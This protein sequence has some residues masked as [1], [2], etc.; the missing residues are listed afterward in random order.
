MSLNCQEIN[1][2]LSELNIDGYF[3][4]DIIQPGY[5]TLALYLYAN[6]TPKTLLIC[7]AQNSCRLHETRRKINKND[8]PLRFME[9][10]KSK[11]KGARIESCYQIGLLRIVQMNL[12][13]GDENFT[14]YIRLWSNASNVI[15]CDKEN[16]IL[17]SMFRRP[18][19]DEVSGGIFKLPEEQIQQKIWPVRD[20][21][22]AQQE[23]KE[24]FPKAPPMTF[25]QKVDYWYGEHAQSLSIQALLAQTEKWY[26]QSRSQM[27]NALEKLLSKRN[28]FENAQ[29]YKHQGDLIMSYSH[30]LDGT[31][32]YLQC[33]DYETGT[34][35]R[36]P[37]DPA[38]SAHENAAT[39]YQQYK[40]AISGAS[41]LDHDIE[42]AKAQIS[43][44]DQQYQQIISEKNP[45]RMEQLFRKDS[46]PKQKIKKTHPG[47]S[48]IINDWYI[49]VGRD[50]NENDELLRH[51]VRGADMWLHVRDFPGGYV[52]IKNR[53]GKTVPLEILLD[54]AN[55]AAY[56]SK[57][58]NAG[59]VDLYYTHVKYLRRAKDGPKGLVLPTH[60]K[61]LCIT[62]DQAR[63]NKLDMLHQT[64]SFEQNPNKKRKSST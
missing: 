36:I 53:P 21:A 61:N 47:L 59:K 14:L 22:E 4:Q 25:N 13:H 7:T 27:E 54:A 55:L 3:I 45:V 50:A 41:A 1:A 46:T 37:V 24:K 31:S 15:L 62:L 2:V 64:S 34:T 6:G 26:N 42:I 48:Y 29:N 30:L 43:K 44:L 49:I 52:F 32:K 19:K 11:V 57:A 56:Y 20:F 5:D 18:G 10:L 16:K 39:Y 63:L 40:K 60:E 33:E 51:H 17:D 58:R 9:F 8:K 35:I 28:D 12:V 38:L 23:D